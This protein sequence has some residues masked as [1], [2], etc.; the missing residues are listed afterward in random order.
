MFYIACS[1]MPRG[2]CVRCMTPTCVTDGVASQQQSSVRAFESETNEA[3]V[4]YPLHTA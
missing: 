3:R 4:L 1:A 2:G